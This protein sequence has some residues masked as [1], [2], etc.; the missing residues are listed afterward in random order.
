MVEQSVQKSCSPPLEVEA[1][2]MTFSKSRYSRLF[3]LYLA[4]SGA[5]DFTAYYDDKT[6]VD[7][8]G[9]KGKDQTKPFG[10]EGSR[11]LFYSGE[12]IDPETFS[13]WNNLDVKIDR[14]SVGDRDVRYLWMLS[15]NLFA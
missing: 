7:N 3:F 4:T 2:A 14:F 11:L 12:G 10:L 6:F 1:I 5:G 9:Q 13:A 8:A 15:C